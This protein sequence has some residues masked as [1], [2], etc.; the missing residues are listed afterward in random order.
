MQEENARLLEDLRGR[1]DVVDQELLATLG[2]RCALVREVIDVKRRE[3]LP[4]RIPQRV[5]EVIDRVI[6][7][8]PAHGASPELA[9]AVW[10]VMIEWFID[11]EEKLLRSGK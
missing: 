5:S 11:H 1:I 2:K 3:G 10:S 8:A 7:T 6:R 4:A 9:G